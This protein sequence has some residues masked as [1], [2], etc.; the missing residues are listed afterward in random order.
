MAEA[1]TGE[2]WAERQRA[3]ASGFDAI[4]TRYDEVFPHK[5]GQIR[6]V[7]QLLGK[8]HFAVRKRATCQH[9]LQPRPRWVA[10]E[11]DREQ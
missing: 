10:G 9:Y 8:L 6:T 2:N 3:Q 7:E 1:T 5:E 4:G 11:P